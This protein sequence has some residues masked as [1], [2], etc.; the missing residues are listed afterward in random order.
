MSNKTARVLNLIIIFIAIIVLFLA[1]QNSDLFVGQ[2]P[3]VPIGNGMPPYGVYPTGQPMYYTKQLYPA[4]M[5]YY[6]DTLQQEGN[7]C[8]SMNGCGVYGACINGKCTIKDVDNKV[9]QKTI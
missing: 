2:V 8:T 4:K 7:P 3:S 1:R 9:Y 6:E 5:P